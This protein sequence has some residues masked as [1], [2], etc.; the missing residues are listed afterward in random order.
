MASRPSIGSNKDFLSWSTQLTQRTGDSCPAPNKMAAA[1]WRACVW[2]D[3]I[4]GST[5]IL[6]IRFRL[7][8]K[9]PEKPWE[10][11]KL[12]ISMDKGRGEGTLKSLAELPV[13]GPGN[14]VLPCSGLIRDKVFSSV[15]LPDGT[16]STWVWKYRFMKTT[17]TLVIHCNKR[18]Q[19]SMIWRKR[20][21]Y[22]TECLSKW[23]THICSTYVL[24]TIFVVVCRYIESCF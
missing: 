24:L 6:L 15:I 1:R 14:I 3:K 8:E 17:L 19:R 21:K 10:V 13:N 9:Q 20:R 4:Y 16:G 11:Y 7:S 5:L 2:R 12:K 23:I 22:K 18:Y